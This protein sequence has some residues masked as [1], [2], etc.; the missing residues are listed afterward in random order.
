MTIPP[1]PQI[2]YRPAVLADAE[3]CAKVYN[4]GW[5]YAFTRTKLISDDITKK[6]AEGRLAG[7]QS[8][9][10]L[11]GGIDKTGRMRIRAV[12]RTGCCSWISLELLNMYIDTNFHGRGIGPN[13]VKE[14]IRLLGWTEK[15]GKM[16]CRVLE[17]NYRAVKFYEKMGGRVVNSEVTTKYSDFEQA[18]LTM[19]W[20]SV[21]DV[22]C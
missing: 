8:T 12:K 20:D 14:G 13:M 1:T 15:D 16:F 7:L 19:G 9:I 4:E 6:V 3:Q 17:R 21:L 2:V 18:L 5:I 10:P 11:H 22:K